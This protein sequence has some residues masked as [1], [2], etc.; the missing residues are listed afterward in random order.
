MNDGT[1][2]SS[3]MCTG[4]GSRSGLV[5]SGVLLP[6]TLNVK[7]VRARSSQCAGASVIE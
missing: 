7:W 3:A 6:R 1:F 2:V 5:I 4:E